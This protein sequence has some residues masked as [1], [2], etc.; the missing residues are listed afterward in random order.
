MAVLV[1]GGTGFVGIHTMRQLALQGETV[2]SVSTRGALDEI[3]M[4]LLGDA[5]G[6]IISEQ[7]DILDLARLKELLHQFEIKTVVHGAA[8]TAIGELERKVPHQAVMVNVGGTV[9]V[10]EAARLEGVTRFIYL[11]S[12]IIY[13]SGDPA[14]PLREERAPQPAGIYAITKRSAESVVERYSELFGMETAILRIS[15]PYGPLERP[16]G[17]RELMSPIYDWCRAAMKGQEITLAEDLERDFTYAA[18]T[19]RGVTL[20]CSASKLP[21][22][23]YKISCG[24]NFR[25]SEVLKLLQRLLPKLRIQYQIPNKMNSFF[26]NTLRG[27]LDT[28]R[29]REHLGFNPEYNLERG[30]RSY[31]AWLERHPV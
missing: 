18:D 16:T 2:V 6:R 22:L 4:E 7:G 26:R 31:L 27:P 28:T 23:L 10:L 15:T 30:L 29:A 11:S 8:I 24:K 17:R 25:F 13:G 5:A 19:A 14:V 20:A 12:A 9:T 1:T 3:A 21:Y